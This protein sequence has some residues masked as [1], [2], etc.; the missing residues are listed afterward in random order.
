VK[1][2]R[3][4]LLGLGAGALVAPLRAALAQRSGR[5]FQVGYLG[6]STPSNETSLVEA[7]R[8]G[9]RERGYTEGKDIVVHYRWAEGRIDRM[10][11]VIAELLALKVDVLVTS[12]TPAVLAARQATTST[13][14][15]MAT[16]GDAVAAG[17]VPS[18]SH[19]GGNIT[20]LS[21]L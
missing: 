17:I 20:G 19:P 14:I 1:T 13:P 15:V 3:R 16:I 9:L 2:R 7:F 10:P 5:M 4:L 8:L 11:G 12:G 6:N 18:L 21:T